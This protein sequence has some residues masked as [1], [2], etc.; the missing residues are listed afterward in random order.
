MKD[1]ICDPTSYL[2]A[3]YGALLFGFSLF[4]LSQPEQYYQVSVEFVL[5]L[6]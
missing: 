4:V 5:L 3:I 6:L 2:I 1:L